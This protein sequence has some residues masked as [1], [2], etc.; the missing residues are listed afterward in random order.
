M[1]TKA[2]SASTKKSATRNL[3]VSADAAKKVKGGLTKRYK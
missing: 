3:R 1:A 2:K